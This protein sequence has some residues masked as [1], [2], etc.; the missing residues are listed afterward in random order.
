MNVHH[1]MHRPSHKNPTNLLM[2][3]YRCGGV[4]KC[5]PQ[6]CW[7]CEFFVLETGM[8]SHFFFTLSMPKFGTPLPCAYQPVLKNEKKKRCKTI[9]NHNVRVHTL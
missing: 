6:N 1:A 2:W 5:Y 7:A 3:G 8:G 4:V 9:N